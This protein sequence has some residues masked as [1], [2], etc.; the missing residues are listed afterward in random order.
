MTAPDLSTETLRRL[1]DEATPGPWAAVSLR[2][3]GPPSGIA[4]PRVAIADDG[5][6]IVSPYANSHLIALAPALAQEVLRLRSDNDVLLGALEVA[7]GNVK[8]E[9]CDNCGGSGLVLGDNGEPTHCP[10][11]KGD[12][13]VQVRVTDTPPP[14]PNL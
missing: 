14:S 8:F 9:D 10:E 6:G 7:V 13:V 3:E 2:I 11:C 12:T 4:I 5:A 1:L